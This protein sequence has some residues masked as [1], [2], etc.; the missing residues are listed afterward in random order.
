MRIEII[1]NSMTFEWQPNESLLDA[2]IRTGHK[3]EYQCREGYC[4]SCRLRCV[5]GQF[6]YRSTPLAYP[7]PQ[8]VIACCAVP[9]THMVVDVSV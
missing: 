4:G 7:L 3:V 8:E 9:R 2:L 5:S 6:E 1:T